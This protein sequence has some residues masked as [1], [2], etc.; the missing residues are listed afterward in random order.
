MISN[1][2]KKENVSIG[3]VSVWVIKTEVK[4]YEKKSVDTFDWHN[5]KKNLWSS[6]AGFF[7][8]GTPTL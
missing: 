1:E 6:R 3:N 5:F 7:S 4:G 8:I 2:Y